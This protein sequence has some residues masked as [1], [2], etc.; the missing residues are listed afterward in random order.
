MSARRRNRWRAWIVLFVL[1]AGMT[2]LAVTLFRRDGIPAGPT[3][4]VDGQAGWPRT[5][6]ERF[7]DGR[8][9]RRIVLPSPPQRIV[10]VTLATDEMLLDMIPLQRIIALSEL[11]PRSGS[12]VADRIGTVPHFVS[13]DV[14][15]IMA[16]DPD[17]CFLASYNR[18]ET[19]S[20]LVDSGIPVCVFHRFACLDD[21][22][23]NIR[24]VGRAVGAERE[25]DRLLLEM[26]RK[27]DEV[28][29]RLPPPDQWPS[30]LVYDESGW[31]AGKGTIQSEV[32][33]AAGL[34]NAACEAQ[35][36]GYAQVSEEQVLEIDPD[37]L[38]VVARRTVGADHREWLVKDPAL[39]P[40]GAI[41]AQRFLTIDESLFSTVSHHIADTIVELARQAYPPKDS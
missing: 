3:T 18:E 19:R 16:L 25:A 4:N 2:A 40:L 23:H 10:S 28:R 24:T 12:L 9:G 21:V 20:L 39:A 31:V 41:R 26:D 32:F 34:R 7:P 6:V 22:R 13:S 15:S 37:Y 30:A 14:E 17:L 36:T 5:L 1:I 33:D 27:I 8:E 29:Q 11:A 38:V 35:I